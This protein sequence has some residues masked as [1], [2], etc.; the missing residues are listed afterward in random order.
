VGQRLAEV[1]VVDPE[2]VDHHATLG[3]ASRAAR[4]EDV[5]RPPRIG[6]RPPAARRPAAEPLVLKQRKLP[7]VLVALHLL[8]RIELQLP[9]LREPKRAAGRAREVMLDDRE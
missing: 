6:L 4:L 8:E 2:I 3:N 9:L 1:L 7:R 5:R